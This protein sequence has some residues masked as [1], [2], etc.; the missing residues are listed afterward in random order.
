M[1]NIDAFLKLALPASDTHVSQKLQHALSGLP[2]ITQV[3]LV[4]NEGTFQHAEL[5]FSYPL[6]SFSLDRVV[7]IIQEAGASIHQIRLHL[8]ASLTGIANVYD[9]RDKA[10]TIL[11]KLTS[12]P[13]ICEP[14]ISNNGTLHIELILTAGSKDDIVKK[15]LHRLKDH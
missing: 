10:D 2:G 6:D 1:N 9:A 5:S 7:I 15:V 14:G 8:P 11:G 4:T 3:M 13:G 12:I